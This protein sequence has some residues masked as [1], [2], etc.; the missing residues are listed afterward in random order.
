MKTYNLGNQFQPPIYGKGIPITLLS[1][2]F[3]VYAC[4][5][6]FFLYRSSVAGR[7]A[8]PFL[9]FC[10]YSSSSG[11]LWRCSA[12]TFGVFNLVTANIWRKLVNSILVVAILNC[13]TGV[14]GIPLGAFTMVESD[15]AS[16][17]RPEFYSLTRNP[18]T[19]SLQALKPNVAAP[20]CCS[21]G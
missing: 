6:F 1:L 8:R 18:G 16:R 10:M 12:A 21:H 13:L 14:L 9:Q 3:I 15:E 4:F 20:H 17:C 2:F 19:W 5:G 11:D 7:R